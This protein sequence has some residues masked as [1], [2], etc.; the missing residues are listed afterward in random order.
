MRSVV[1]G[2]LVHAQYCTREVNIMYS[3]VHVTLVTCAVLYTQ[4]Y[5]YAQ[6]CTRNVSIIRCVVHVRFESCTVLYA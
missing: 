1:H 6:S 2:T 5:Y 4:I 3:V